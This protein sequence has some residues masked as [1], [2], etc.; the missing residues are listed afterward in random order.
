MS[1][2]FKVLFDSQRP[3]GRE[4][5]NRLRV[6]AHVRVLYSAEERLAIVTCSASVN[7][8]VDHDWLPARARFLWEEVSAASVV[9]LIAD[10][11][12]HWTGIVEEKIPLGFLAPAPDAGP[13]S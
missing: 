11:W 8:D 4:G 10:Q 9:L 12:K 13:A 5:A 6:F 7:D 3:V 1:V 2:K